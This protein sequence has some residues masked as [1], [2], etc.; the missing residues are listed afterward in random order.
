V[1]R[2]QAEH[3]TEQTKRL[4][5]DRNQRMERIRLEAEAEALRAQEARAARAAQQAQA[6]QQA[7]EETV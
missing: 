5:Q 7:Q 6:K 3:K 1:K 2:Q 4:M